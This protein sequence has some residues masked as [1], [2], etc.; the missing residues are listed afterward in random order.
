M[1]SSVKFLVANVTVGLPLPGREPV[2]AV[3]LPPEPQ[4][5]SSITKTASAVARSIIDLILTGS[6]DGGHRGRPVGNRT[7]RR[8]HR[9]GGLFHRQLHVDREHVDVL[10]VRA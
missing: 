8:A 10:A 9:L 5:A 3:G 2:R 6:L 7:E 4:P 1:N